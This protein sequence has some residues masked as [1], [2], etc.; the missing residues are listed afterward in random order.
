M[1]FGLGIDDVFKLH[2]KSGENTLFWHDKWLGPTTLGEKYPSLLDLESRKKC[3]VADRIVNVQFE[4]HWTSQVKDEGDVN[5]ANNLIRDL[6][7]VRLAQGEDQWKY[8]VDI[9][10]PFRVRTLR[11]KLD[12]LFYPNRVLPCFRWNKGSPIKVNRFIWRSIQ[13]K[14]PSAMALRNRGIDIKHDNCGACINDTECSDQILI[15]CPFA[16]E[17]SKQVFNWCN[18]Q[19][20]NFASVTDLLS[21]IA[22]WGR[23]RKKRKRFI[24]I[25]YGLIWNLWKNRNDR[26]FNRVFLNP[27]LSLGTIKSLVFC[28]LKCRGKGGI[29]DWND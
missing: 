26:A 10:S 15:S 24:S 7:E 3:T 25:C 27:T 23:C 28:W 2:V 16:C 21:F 14:I 20:E 4:G 6:S 9:T 5:N 29:C 22:N 11:K 1:K 17:V 12:Q 13:K 8:V 19:Q 18:I